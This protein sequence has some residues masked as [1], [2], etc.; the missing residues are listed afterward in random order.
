MSVYQVKA[1]S[2]I[3]P[4]FSLSFLFLLIVYLLLPVDKSVCE[5]WICAFMLL[6]DD[7]SEVRSRAALL[8]QSELTL[9]PQKSLEYLVDDFVAV[10]KN[11]PAYALATL[12]VLSIGPLPDSNDFDIDEASKLSL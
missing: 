8:C 1:G 2:S 3:S 4:F 10:M 11:S 6:S 12:I 5:L 7:N 9:L